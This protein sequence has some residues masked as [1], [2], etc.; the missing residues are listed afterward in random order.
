MVRKKGE[1]RGGKRK[2]REKKKRERNHKTDQMKL[3]FETGKV[4]NKGETEIEMGLSK[5]REE[6]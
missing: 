3:G 6:G 4:T 5:K 2:K 1:K